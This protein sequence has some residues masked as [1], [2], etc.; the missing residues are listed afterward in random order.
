VQIKEE[1]NKILFSSRHRREKF[2]I[3]EK[4]SKMA[5]GV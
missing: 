1:K 5:L 2:K 4:N 3:G